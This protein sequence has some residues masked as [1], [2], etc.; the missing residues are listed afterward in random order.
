MA[1]QIYRNAAMMWV[2][3]MPWHGLGTELPANAT[4]ERVCEVVGFYQVEERPL[5]VPGLTEPIDD[6]KALVRKD[7]GEYL[8][9]VGADYG[10]VQFSGMA[11]AVMTAAGKEAVFHTAGLLG[12]KG[13]R[14]WLLGELPNPIKVKGDKSE[15][16]KYILATGAHTGWNK[17]VFKNVATRVVCANTVAAALHEKDGAFERTIRHTSRASERLQ[18]AAKAFKSV[19]EGYEKFGQLANLLAGVKLNAEK[20]RAVIDAVLPLHKDKDNSR[21]IQAR[22]S[23]EALHESAVGLDGIKGTAWGAYQAWTEWADHHQNFRA[24]PGRS[25]QAVRLESVWLGRSADLKTEALHALADVAGVRI[26]A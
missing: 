24:L 6:K 11:E 4:W 18:S 10:V 7:T 9:T 5:F 8:S 14:G 17:I 16:R 1:H 15:I 13:I 22:Q 21:R 23:V 2:G 19:A 26:A 3:Q 20:Q 25:A 12:E